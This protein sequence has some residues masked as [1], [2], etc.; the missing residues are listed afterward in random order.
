[1]NVT[2]PTLNS[3]AVPTGSPNGKGNGS[4]VVLPA[5]RFA[6]APARPGA[7]L[8]RLSDSLADLARLA[9]DGKS[10]EQQKLIIAD[11]IEDLRAQ[12]HPIPT[13]TSTPYLNTIPAD[14]QPV[15]PGDLE[16]EH[17]LKSHIRWNA[18]AMVVKANTNTNVGGHISTFASSAT[19]YE[20]GQNHFFRGGDGGRT[21]DFVYFQG[22]AS[23][24]PYARSYLEGRITE[25][26]LHNFRIRT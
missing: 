26:Q 3:S 15:Y 25:A 23:P 7:A 8:T 1:V 2:L 17:Q 21:A 12:G 14:Q 19:L 10:A 6:E 20:V 11:F 22:H 9:L 5:G 4:P 16:L 18:M 13:V 24:G